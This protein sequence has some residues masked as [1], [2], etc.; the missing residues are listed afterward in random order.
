MRNHVEFPRLSI[1]RWIMRAHFF[2]M[3]LVSAL[4]LSGCATKTDAIA[5]GTS[6]KSERMIV[7]V[8]ITNVSGYTA[9]LYVAGSLAGTL[10][11]NQSITVPLKPT[12]HRPR[13]YAVA[14]DG[15]DVPR[16]R[17]TYSCAVKLAVRPVYERV[18]VEPF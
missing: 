15:C 14:T 3:F 6:A 5:E 13:V 1:E 17:N 8:A 7:E 9:D 11:A 10:L 4:L 16:D 18:P 12:T 2:R